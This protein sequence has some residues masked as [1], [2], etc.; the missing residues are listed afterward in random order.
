MFVGVFELLEANERQVNAG[1]DY[2]QTMLDYWVFRSELEKA[3]G[4]RLPT[5]PMQPVVVEDIKSAPAMHH[6]RE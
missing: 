6:H 4:K 1:R 2:I 5:G 3:I